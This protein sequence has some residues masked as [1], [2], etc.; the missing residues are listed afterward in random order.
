VIHFIVDDF[1]VTI[2]LLL[3]VLGLPFG[4]LGFNVDR[5]VGVASGGGV[6]PF[7]AFHPAMMTAHHRTVRIEGFLLDL[8]LIEIQLGGDPRDHPRRAKHLFEHGLDL[9]PQVLFHLV[10]V[11]ELGGGCLEGAVGRVLLKDH[12]AVGAHDGHAVFLQPFDSTCHQ[13]NNALRLTL[14]EAGS[15]LQLQDHRGACRLLVFQEERVLGQYQVHA[16]LQDLVHLVDGAAQ[17]ALHGALIVDLLHELG[18]AKLLLVKDFKPRPRASGDAFSGKVHPNLIK[19][20]AG[21]RQRSAPRKLVGQLLLLQ[22]F[23]NH[24]CFAFGEPGKERH[25]IDLV[26]EIEGVDQAG[27]NQQPGTGIKH[28]LRPG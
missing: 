25:V 19:L 10:S 7:M 26:G 11:F 5:G 14:V 20:V 15:G 27:C 28:L 2:L 9:L 18:A 1:L 3:R 21:Y 8:G 6:L 22:G 24:S 23:H 17:F 4:Q 12:L 13:V 16:A